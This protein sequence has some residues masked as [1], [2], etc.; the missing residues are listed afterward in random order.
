MQAISLE[1]SSRPEPAAAA[2]PQPRPKKPREEPAEGPP[3]EP[4]VIVAAPVAAP[5]PAL[6]PAR[7]ALEVPAMAIVRSYY[8]WSAAAGLLP[9]PL[10]DFAAIV[11]VQAK[12]V[13]ELVDLYR[14]PVDKRLVRPLITSLLGTSGGFAVAGPLVRLLWTV[15]VLGPLASLFT[16]PAMATASCWATGRVFIDHFESGRSLHDFD[17]V[18]A[19]ADYAAQLILAKGAI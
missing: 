13:G 3:E 8:S 14:K 7:P 18:K 15:P 4:T 11:G 9:V 2:N 1:A 19:R 12:M 5:L 6:L 16:L 10:L 17:P